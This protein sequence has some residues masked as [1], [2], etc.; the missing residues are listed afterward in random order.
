MHSWHTVGAAGGRRR[1][2][3]SAGRAPAD[4]LREQKR[5]VREWFVGGVVSLPYRCCE[6]SRWLGHQWGSV[7]EGRGGHGSQWGPPRG[8]QTVKRSVRRANEWRSFVRL[9]KSG[10]EKAENRH[11]SMSSEWL[12]SS[13]RWGSQPQPSGGPVGPDM[14]RLGSPGGPA[15]RERMALE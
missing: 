9:A 3:V 2:S 11:G 12:P 10:R 6:G 14:G 7:W 5:T 4:E 1:R 13:L 8:R 15:V